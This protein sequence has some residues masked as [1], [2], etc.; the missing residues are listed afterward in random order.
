MMF[1]HGVCHRQACK[2]VQMARSTQQY[3]SRLKDDAAVIEA[4]ESTV[5]IIPLLIFGKI[6]TGFN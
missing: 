3:R 2:M 5:K 4:L 1:H 6:I